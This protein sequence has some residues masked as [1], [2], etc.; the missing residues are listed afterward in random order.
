MSHRRLLV[1]ILAACALPVLSS[2]STE[3]GT[4]A[5]AWA[6]CYEDTRDVFGKS[7][8]NYDPEDPYSRPNGWTAQAGTGETQAS[9]LL[10]NSGVDG[11]TRVPRGG[12]GRN[13]S[14]GSD[15]WD[16]LIDND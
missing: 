2:C 14:S 3:P 15:F 11:G 13:E 9:R 12:Q 5:G 1:V 8:V 6:D 16:W 10:F 4:F 7:F